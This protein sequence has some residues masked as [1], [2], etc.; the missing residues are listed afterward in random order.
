M[1][2][3]AACFCSF[4]FIANISFA[5]QS[6]VSPFSSPIYEQYISQAHQLVSHM[7]LEKK[8]GQMLV[9]TFD[10][11]AD[12]WGKN[13]AKS[14]KESWEK[15]KDLKKLGQ[16]CGLEGIKKYHL[17][18]LL[19]AGTPLT[20]FDKQ[21]NANLKKLAEL[22]KSYYD[23]PQGTSLL[24]GTDA[25][26]GN[27]H[28]PG[29]VLFPHNIGL[30][31]THDPELIKQ[32]G[33]WTAHDVALSGF[34]WAY[35]P[36][37][38]IAQDYRWGRT[39][40]SFSSDPTIV[41]LLA[42]AYIDGVQN[43]RADQITGVLAAAKH[44]IGDGATKN[45][46]DEGYSETADLKKFWQDQG[47]GYRGA[48]EANV[49]S[50]IASYSS[51]NDVPM[52][53]GGPTNIL[54]TFKEKGLS[55]NNNTFR[56]NGFIVSDYDG[57]SRAMYK[58]NLTHK[59]KMDYLHG[60]A[61]AINSGVDMLM[62][63]DGGVYENPFAYEKFPPYKMTSPLLFQD[64]KT[65]RDTL[66]KAATEKLIPETRIDD[67]VTRIIAVKLAMQDSGKIAINSNEKEIALSAAEESFVL[68]K[69]KDHVLPLKKSDIKNVILLGK[70]DDI[71]SQSGGWTVYWQ[72]QMGNVIWALPENKSSANAYSVKDGIEKVLG[73][74]V[75]IISGNKISNELSAYPPKNTIA[76][77]TLAEPPYA[78][79]MG[80]V[81][82]QNPWYIR[83]ALTGE[84]I[85]MPTKQS[86]FLGVKFS[87]Q[88]SKIIEKLKKQGI[89]IITVLFSGR[90]MVITK[91]GKKAPLNN[92]DAFIAGFLPG[93]TG[94]L[95]IADTLFGEY[96]LKSHTYENKGQVYF[97]N[98][99]P[100]AW[101]KKMEEVKL[102]NY[103][104]F[105][106][107]Y[108]LKN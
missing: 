20:F 39:Y 54:N 32:I 40:E 99:L 86:K 28:I 103:T 31:A 8:I 65:V 11:L 81:D 24:L 16:L 75:N 64:V 18:A 51:L 13:T 23:G 41:K 38:A 73:N 98:T 84:N 85:N 44:F 107:S 56:F 70:Y 60:V 96:H 19:A 69:N 10:L 5:E 21:T 77:I 101:P 3:T 63:G 105:P 22:S 25:V 83:G 87:K 78:E 26:H 27:Q 104:L 82:N 74:N 36:T 34:N 93:P 7:T 9:P 76:I 42:K 37:V 95:A 14:C 79:Y 59:D 6:V 58:Y 90:P 92:S 100:F 89:K 46:E 2:R 94:G 91:G 45:G 30:G 33:Q 97:S 1:M 29:A 71:G 15:E 61:K 52:N 62:L 102:H 68:L 108:G 55:D 53:F 4:F 35:V 106:V 66:L 72:G 43:I 50:I 17:G 47:A 88:E 80:D 57:V 49:G 67:A 12:D 48:I